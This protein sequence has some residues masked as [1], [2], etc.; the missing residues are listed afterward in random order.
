MIP[1]WLTLSLAV[2]AAAGPLVGIL[3]G[4]FLTRSWQ[5][6]QWLM[7]SRKQEYRELLTTLTNTYIVFGQYIGHSIALDPQTR[8]EVDQAERESYRVVRDRLFIAKD[9]QE[10][11]ILNLWATAVENYKQG[12]DIKVFAKRF[13]TSMERSWD[14]PR[15]NS[16]EEPLQHII[17]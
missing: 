10:A 12:L 1:L 17:R 2:W 16:N 7:D 3:V 13:T 15:V 6:T 11:D 8:R 14:W 4:H 5:R 9:L